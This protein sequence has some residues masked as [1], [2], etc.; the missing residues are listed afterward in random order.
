MP[1]KPSQ[2][3]EVPT[4][5]WLVLDW[6]M[7]YL[8]AP[9][10]IEYEP[11]QPT[12]EQAQFILNFYALHPE[13]GRRRY[14][15]GVISRPKGWG[16]SPLLAAIA[17]AEGIG[18]VI[19][20][21]WDADG[22][23]VGKP[24]AEIRTPWIQVAATTE[25]QSRNS[26]TPLLEMLREGP[27][28]DEFPGL[29]PFETFVN[30]P[31]GRI[32]TITSVAISREGNRPVFCVMDQ[33]ESWL[34][35]NGGTR[36]AAT[37]R[38]NLGKTN[39]SSI[40]SPNAYHPG[41]LSV[42]ERSADYYRSIQEG[43]ARDEGLLYD[44]REA[45]PETDLTDRESLL[46]GLTVAYGDAAETNGGWVNLDRII[47]EIWDPG[48]DPQDARAFYLGQITHA[49][50]AW[51][52]APEWAA[53][54]DVLKIVADDD[55]VTLGFDGSRHR[56]RGVTDSTAIVGCRVS[57]GHVFPIQVWEQPEY[58]R[59]WW[60]PTVE[61]EAAITSVFNDY[62]VVGFY[63]DP[64]ADWR[65]FVAGW[66]AR[67]GSQLRVRASRDH[68]IEWWMGGGNA[69]R[70]VRATEQLHSAIIHKDMSHDGTSILTRHFLNARRRA[71]RSGIQIAKDMPD[72]PRKIDAAVAAILAWQARLDAL[73]AGVSVAAKKSKK[74]VRF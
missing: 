21:G 56:S 74:L 70:S 66:E 30:L 13:T 25:D 63:A 65:S 33:T 50:D 15:R 36:L 8:A 40:E 51:L 37:L 38:R 14:R 58:Q 71:S 69:I 34:P 43:R 3:D 10:R 54:A 27:A 7:E 35:G 23:P 61:V 64:A 53:C 1:W 47:E 31:R 45:P 22:Q 6:I 12:T 57:D 26:W 20:D 5:G 46:S 60:V 67:F 41:L 48:T 28:V 17:C 24:W 29:E 9:D 19:P 68:P 44:H 42:A 4:L 55:M 49:A 62:N 2:P 39:G 16:K 18:P 52:S 73:A 59:D 11:F 72:S 32:E